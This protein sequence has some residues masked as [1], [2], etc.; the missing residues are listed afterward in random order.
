MNSEKWKYK[1]ENADYCPFCGGK[2]VSVA[3]KE[4]RL[5]GVTYSGIKKHLMQAYCICNKCHAKGM[6]VKY[7]GYSN[8]GYGFY[9]E[10]H[11]PVY[12]CG[13]KAVDAWNRREVDEGEEHETD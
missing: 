11:L 6:P 10:E 4:V 7:V 9:D 5:L 2:S 12:S 13:D 8:A 1:V 3:H